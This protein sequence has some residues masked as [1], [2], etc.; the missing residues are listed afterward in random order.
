MNCVT[1]L[2]R[3]TYADKVFVFDWYYVHQKRIPADSTD[4]W[5]QA[6]QHHLWRMESK[7]SWF[8]E[9]MSL[10]GFL[11]EVMNNLTGEKSGKLVIV[12][13]VWLET[14]THAETLVPAHRHWQ[15]VGIW[16]FFLFYCEITEVKIS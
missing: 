3:T 12:G 7:T 9:V 16:D 5:S 2:I 8:P 11:V 14:Q 15:R 1:D 13:S 4:L 6:L 10:T